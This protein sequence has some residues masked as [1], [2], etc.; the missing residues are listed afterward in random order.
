MYF[1]GSKHSGTICIF[2]VIDFKEILQKNFQIEWGS[3]SL[4]VISSGMS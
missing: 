1:C 3:L 2:P 4:T